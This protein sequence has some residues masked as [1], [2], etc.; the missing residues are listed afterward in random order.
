MSR[1][2]RYIAELRKE[3]TEYE[4]AAGLDNG[5]IDKPSW[6]CTSNVN[7]HIVR[8][9]DYKNGSQYE[10]FIDIDGDKEDAE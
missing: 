3:M 5:D 4:I 1:L 6:L 9:W 8:V 10:K 2:T 7:S